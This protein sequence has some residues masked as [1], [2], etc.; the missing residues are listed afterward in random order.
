MHWCSPIP[1]DRQEYMTRV[2]IYMYADN[3]LAAYVTVEW[4]RAAEATRQTNPSTIADFFT[5][6]DLFWHGFIPRVQEGSEAL[7]QQQ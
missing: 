2:A 1:L 3:Y 5:N 7:L 4:W 6:E